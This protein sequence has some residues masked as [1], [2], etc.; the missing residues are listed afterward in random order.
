MLESVTVH[1]MCV[2]YCRNLV[3]FL[4]KNYYALPDK[5]GTIIN[6]YLCIFV[7][8]QSHE[9]CNTPIVYGQICYRFAWL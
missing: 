9:K 1:T 2:E 6:G 8:A 5:N 7:T 3:Y 4:T